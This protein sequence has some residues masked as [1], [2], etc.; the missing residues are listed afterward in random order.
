[1]SKL[2]LRPTPKRLI[3][4]VDDADNNIGGYETIGTKEHQVFATVMRAGKELIA[5]NEVND[6]DRIIIGEN[7]GVTFEYN[8]VEYRLLYQEDIYATIE[9]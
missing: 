8:E 9:E 6:G 4:L 3:V 7:A 2:N 5:S 1:M